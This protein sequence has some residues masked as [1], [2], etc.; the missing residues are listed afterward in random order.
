MNFRLSDDAFDGGDNTNY[1]P[2]NL[3]ATNLMDWKPEASDNF[4][5]TIESPSSP[6]AT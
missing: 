5:L 1:P 4:P 3:S 6:F 2:D